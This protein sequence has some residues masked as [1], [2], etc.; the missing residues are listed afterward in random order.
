MTE[1]MPFGQEYKPKAGPNKGVKLK[2]ARSQFAETV[3]RSEKFEETADAFMAE[4][5]ARN[6][7]AVELAKILM[8]LV[9]DTTLSQNKSVMQ[10]QREMAAIA[11]MV[12]FA[13]TINEDD[14]EREGMGGVALINLVLKMLFLQRDSL[15]EARYEIDQLKKRVVALQNNAAS[16][17]KPAE[18]K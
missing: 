1:R 7:H 3:E 5:Q 8:E 11:D 18:S 14:T 2:N 17:E 13:L 12:E 4:K 6:K 9:K 16:K 15:N 10:K